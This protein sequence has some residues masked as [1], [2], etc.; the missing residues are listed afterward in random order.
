MN[1]RI[2]HQTEYHYEEE[3]ALSHSLVACHPRNTPWQNC[4]SHDIWIEPQPEYWVKRRDARGNW[5]GYFSLE[6][7]HRK[8]TL[9]CRSLVAVSS[10]PA[11]GATGSWEEVARLSRDHLEALAFVYPSPATPA[12]AEILDYARASFSPGRSWLEALLDLQTRIH[13]DFAYVP[14]STR[15]HTPI[16]QAFRQRKGVCQDF[17]HLML[18][19]LRGMGLPA[20]YVSGY[21]LTQPP[22][23]QARLVGADASHAWVSCWSPENDWLDFDPTNN[24]LC[25]ESHILL[26]W[27]REYSEVAPVRGVVLGGGRQQIRVAVDV[28]PQGASP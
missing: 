12:E 7:P 14:G 21:L 5:V 17:A 11:P 9:S 2:R 1:Y 27:G 19:M 20:R 10:R 15:V 24:R 23:G 16:V 3:V 4:L 28:V 8:L 18:A 13:Q 25:D 26:A 22:P 6:Q